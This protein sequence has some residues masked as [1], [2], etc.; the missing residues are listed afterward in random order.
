MWL[1]STANISTGGTAT[2]LTDDVHPEVKYAAERIGRLIGLDIIGIDLLAETLTKPL[3]QQSAGV[4]EVNAGPGFRM[5]LSPTHGKGRD[6]GKAVVDMLFPDEDDG[7]VPITAITGTN[8]KT[9]TTRLIAHLLRHSGRKVGMACTGTVE[10]DN[11]V[12]LR[13]D[14]SGPARGADG[15]EGARS[16]RGAGGGAGRHHAPRTRLRRL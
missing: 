12:V 10:I 6:V 15:V 5:H 13:G 8:G 14:Y 9:T 3:D 7:R 16:T 2:D 4:V 1:K 11:H